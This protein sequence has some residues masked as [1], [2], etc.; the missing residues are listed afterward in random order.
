M[1][2]AI[3]PALVPLTLQ[4]AN[5]SSPPAK[6]MILRAFQYLLLILLRNSVRRCNLAI[7]FWSWCKR[8]MSVEHIIFRCSLDICRLSF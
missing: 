7:C 6:K 4:N 2:A 8:V 5:A 1:N 3:H